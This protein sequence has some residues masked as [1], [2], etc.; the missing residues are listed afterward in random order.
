MVNCQWCR[1]KPLNLYHFH[2][3]FNER[4]IGNA[5]IESWGLVCI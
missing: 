4:Y 1:A 5:L 2:L 3:R